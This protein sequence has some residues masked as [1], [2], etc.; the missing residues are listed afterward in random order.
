MCFYRDDHV[1][2]T[3]REGSPIAKRH[4]T[5]LL[6]DSVFVSDIGT[7]VEKAGGSWETLQNLSSKLSDEQRRQFLTKPYKPGQSK[8]LH[9]HPVTKNNKTWTVSFQKA[10]L[11]RFPWLSYS[12][13]ADGGLCRYCILFPEQPPRGG[14]QGGTPGV[15][16]LS[17][18]QYSYAKALGKDGVL[19]CH[20]QSQM[21]RNAQK[22]VDIFL[23]TQLNPHAHID[24]QLLRQANHQEQTNKEI[25]REIVR[26][27]EFLAKQGLPFRGHRDSKV[28]FAEDSSNKG[29][30]VATLQLLGKSNQTLQDHLLSAQ[31][32]A[33][34]SSKTIQNEI[35]HIYGDKI[36]EIV[37]KQIR[38]NALP[39]TVIADEFTDSYSNQ[40]ILSVCIRHVDLSSPGVPEIKEFLIGFLHIERANANTI[41]QK[42]VE[43]VTVPS[44]SLDPSKIRGQAYDGAAVM[45]SEVAG[46]KAKIKEIAPLAI[47]THCYSHCLNLTIAAM[48]SVQ[49]VRNLV[50]LINEAYYFLANH[51]K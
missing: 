20:E 28:Y 14:N 27:V 7:L 30:F 4:H 47:Y 18:Y 32:N 37:S 48:C 35:I 12:N 29:N 44:I 51:P 24:T 42:I 11:D 15:L 36:R 13:V 46:V 40:V 16:I 33:K 2:S 8:A 49:E 25:L 41:A 21:H 39:F 34:Y 45:S 23:H 26:A 19:V 22:L 17:A 10:W 1:I 50:G 38:E 43:A 9:S 31:K 5:I 6:E 3:S